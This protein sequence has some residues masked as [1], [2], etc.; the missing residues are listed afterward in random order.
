MALGASVP[1][2]VVIHHLALLYTVNQLLTEF[3]P[4]KFRNGGAKMKWPERI[5]FPSWLSVAAGGY[6]VLG[7]FGLTFWVVR[8]AWPNLDQRPI[9]IASALVA[10]PLALALVWQRLATLKF[11]GIEVSLAHVTVSTEKISGVLSHQQYFSGSEHLITQVRTAI[12]K[13]EIKLI[14]VN[15]HTEPYW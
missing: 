6:A 1:D 5:H 7:V 10:A 8:S 11:F 9:V 4:G 12:M 14:E 15:L 13:P 3:Q 2:C